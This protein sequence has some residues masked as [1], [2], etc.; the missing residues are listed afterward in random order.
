MSRSTRYPMHTITGQIDKD[1][2]HRAVRKHV[3]QTLQTMDL[4]DPPILD[5]EGNTRTLGHEEW[6]TKF[7]WDPSEILTEEENEDRKR[8]MRK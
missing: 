3:R 6:G 2:A 4:D 5:I 8:C 1:K 7:G